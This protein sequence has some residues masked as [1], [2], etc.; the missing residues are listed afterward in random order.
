MA[1]RFLELHILHNVPASRLNSNEDGE[2][3]TLTYGNVVRACVSSQCW[4][5]AVRHTASGPPTPAR[6]ACRW[7]S[8][9]SGAP[10]RF[11]SGSRT[12]LTGPWR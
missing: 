10:S 8:G 2:P 9:R 3:K 5:H 12:G 1:S 4:K 6:G 11:V 7:R